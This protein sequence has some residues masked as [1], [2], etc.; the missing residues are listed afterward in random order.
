MSNLSGIVNALLAFYAANE[1]L[2]LFLFLVLEEAGV[3]I[4]FIPG[5]TLVMAAGARPG[6]TPGTVLQILLAATAGA[7]VGSSVLYTIV[8]RGG[9]PMLDRY[10]HVLHLNESRISTLQGWLQRYGPLAIVAGRLIPGLRTPTTVMA[11]LFEVPY[12]MF[13]PSTAVAALLWALLYFF[14]GSLLASQWQNLLTLLATEADDIAEVVV[15]V[16]LLAILGGALLRR[17][18]RAQNAP[19]TGNRSRS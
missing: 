4:W 7:F 12:W 13:A 5:D 11:G 17:R 2:G 19:K 14:A 10:G 8:R 15:A 18:R 1:A 16:V 9:R 6:N 3:P